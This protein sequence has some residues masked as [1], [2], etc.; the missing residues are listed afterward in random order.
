MGAGAAA[1][2]AAEAAEAVGTPLMALANR[3]TREAVEAADDATDDDERALGLPDERRTS[4]EADAILPFSSDNTLRDGTPSRRFDT[5]SEPSGTSA[6][7]A[8][9]E[10]VPTCLRG[11]G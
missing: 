9:R 11:D 10:S 7:V 8:R 6:G 3:P 5:A 4:G 2:A 1:A